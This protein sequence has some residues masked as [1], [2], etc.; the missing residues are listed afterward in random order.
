MLEEVNAC[1]LKIAY[2]FLKRQN[3][4]I[5]APDPDSIRTVAYTHLD[6]YKRQQF[7]FQRAK[8]GIFF[9]F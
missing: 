1:F 3:L 6:V 2:E 7:S 8:F 4:L 9:E 5:V